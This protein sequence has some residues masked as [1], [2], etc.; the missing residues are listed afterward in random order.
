MPES[1]IETVSSPFTPEVQA[2]I[3]RYLPYLEEI[4]KKFVVVVGIFLVSS[5]I[6]GFFYQSI[7]RF[8]L[9]HFNL[10][11]VNMVL[12]SPNQIIELGIETG[13][14]F[15]CVITAPICTYFF[16]KFL[17]P[18]LS[19]K[20]F[21]LII[22]LLPATLILFVIGF[23]FGIW[24]MQFIIALF[25]S[26][27]TAINTSNLWD[28]G[29][30]FNQIIISGALMGLLFEFPIVLTALIRLHVLKRA[31]LVKQR[32]FVYTI[33][34]IAAA[35]GPSTDLISLVLLT[36]P[37]LLLFEITLLLNKNA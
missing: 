20:E 21:R 29:N 7:F 11:G 28:I 4:R 35:L 15:G 17:K 12:T 22:S 6:S 14:F 37:L 10:T 8:V 24:V 18:A 23:S 31:L 9:A 3:D 27:A 33:I 5:I 2:A 25:A 34:L 1:K 16:L 36:I 26:S 19:P 30:F 13:L 32:P